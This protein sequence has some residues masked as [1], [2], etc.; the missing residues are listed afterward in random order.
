MNEKLR[1]IVTAAVF[2]A[3]TCVATMLIQIPTLTRG[4]VNLG[5]CMVLLAGWICGAKWGAA[6]AGI[7]SA[8][9]DMIAG[10]AIYAPGTF[11][12]KALMAVIAAA[13]AYGLRSHPL[14]AHIISGVTAEIFM[15]AGYFLYEWLFI[16]GSAATAVI[17]VP[18][19]LIQGAVGVTA[20][21]AL[22]SV[23][24]FTL[25]RPGKP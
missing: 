16:T 5:D 8:L 10:Y 7:G 13:V 22:M 6:A 18:E 14:K 25:N 3:L 4:Y 9:A 15:A 12:V 11:I 19:N 1:N 20:A 23:K 2:A 21:T 17:G 24:A